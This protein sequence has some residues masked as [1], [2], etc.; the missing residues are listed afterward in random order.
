MTDEAH[1]GEFR[2]TRPSAASVGDADLGVG[3]PYPA[4]HAAGALTSH[5][6]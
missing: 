3:N 4:S 1:H 2:V 5:I 6:P